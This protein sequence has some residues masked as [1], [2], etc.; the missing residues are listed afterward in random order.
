MSIFLKKIVSDKKSRMKSK[1]AIISSSNS[2]AK[3]TSQTLP[4]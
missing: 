4:S 3:L 1:L 2:I